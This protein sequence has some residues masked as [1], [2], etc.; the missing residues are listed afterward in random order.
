M[1]WRDFLAMQVFSGGRKEREAMN[2]RTDRP[3]KGD[4][5]SAAS[6]A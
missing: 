6:L 3:K 4:R 1:S 2:E 5:E